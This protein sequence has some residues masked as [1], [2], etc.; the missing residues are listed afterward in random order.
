MIAY[1]ENSNG[2][3][4]DLL[5]APYRMINAD[6]FDSDWDETDTGYEKTVDIDVF[7]KQ[8]DFA[9]NMEQLYKII[10]VDSERGVYGKLYINDTYLR[11]NIRKSR[12]A[13]WKGFVYS[14]VEMVFYAPVLEWIQE[15]RKSF[16]PQSGESLT[17][18]FN[19][20]FN[21]PF[22]FT[23]E[24]RGVE[25]WRI[26]HVVASDF[27]MVIYGSCMDPKIY[28]NGYPY[29][30]NTEL[31]ENEYLILDSK[32]CT[33]LKF[34]SDGTV[35]NIFHERG[36]EYSVFE[37]IP[38]GVLTLN[39]PGKFGFDLTLFLIRREPKW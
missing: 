33:I 9:A 34:N 38:S 36:Y 27:Q 13:G 20:P 17:E 32:N 10:A 22:N 21:F 15:I 26:D 18:G 4:L 3:K 19:F 5:K 2:E 30:V 11:C 35:S 8:E 6:I 31:H 7:G 25:N 24:S 12:K 1:Y 16:Y 39:W 28:I 14:E 23:Q 29:E 37:K